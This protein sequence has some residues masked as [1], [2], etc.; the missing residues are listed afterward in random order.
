MTADLF[1]YWS[2]SIHGRCGSTLVF[3]RSVFFASSILA[4]HTIAD[5]PFDSTLVAYKFKRSRTGFLI[6]RTCRAFARM[7]AVMARPAKTI[8]TGAC[9]PD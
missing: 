5:S 1:A 2:E 6:H 8:G 9:T 7:Y 4:A 3:N